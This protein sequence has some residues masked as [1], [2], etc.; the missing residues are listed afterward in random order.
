MEGESE[1]EGALRALSCLIVYFFAHK[2]LFDDI[3]D[4]FGIV[5]VAIC[6]PGFFICSCLIVY[7]AVA[8]LL[9]VIMVRPGLI[10]KYFLCSSFA[11]EPVC[12]TC[13]FNKW[14][15]VL[16]GVVAEMCGSEW[17]LIIS[18]SLIRFL[19]HVLFKLILNIRNK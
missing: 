2:V 3:A 18:R 16:S 12:F 7:F 11:C 17:T 9:L 15:S 8:L 19:L 1:W 14:Q 4:I 6:V 10:F 13:P 5:V